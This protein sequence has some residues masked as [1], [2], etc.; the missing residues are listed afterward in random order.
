MRRVFIL[1][2]GFA[3]VACSNPEPKSGLMPG[4]VTGGY[5][6]PTNAEAS[7]TFM[8][9]FQARY[10]IPALDYP[11]D[12]KKRIKKARLEKLQKDMKV[13]AKRQEFISKLAL[14][15]LA[16]KDPE[17]KKLLEEIQDNPRAFEQEA[18]LD[19]IG[20]YLDAGPKRDSLSTTERNS[21][22]QSAIREYKRNF[23]VLNI[24]SCRWTE[25]TRLIGTGHEAMAR[26]YGN[27]PTHGF[28]CI[29]DMKIEK[30]KGYPRNVNFRGFL[31]KSP[32][33][34]W[35]YY[36]KFPG[37]GISA[38][39]QYLD[40]NLMQNPEQTIARQDIWD[41]LTSQLN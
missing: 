34:D 20:P 12:I 28:E 3:T 23:R 22:Y 29:G 21:I 38:R 13:A 9:A 26:I 16:Q 35:R 27:H 36:G 17:A 40:S 30:R 11:N 41:S 24:E 15:V 6:A 2:F 31:I 5:E 4:T 32:S 39:R 8:A 33:G 18:S 37:V 7:A 14:R 1:L 25:M 19:W 10:D